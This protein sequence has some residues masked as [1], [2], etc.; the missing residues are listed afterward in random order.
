MRKMLPHSGSLHAINAPHPLPDAI[1]IVYILAGQSCLLFYPSDLNS[2]QLL[3]LSFKLRLS[4]YACVQQVF[5]FYNIVSN[6]CC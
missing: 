1:H 6:M 5:V 3:F 4:D 2:Q